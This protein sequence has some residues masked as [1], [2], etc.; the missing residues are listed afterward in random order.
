MSSQNVFKQTLQTVSHVLLYLHNNIYEM[1]GPV[2]L[3]L[4]DEK[5]DMKVPDSGGKKDTQTNY[6]LAD[7]LAYNCVSWG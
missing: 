7:L 6:Y 3:P 4:V 1:A 5:P 2:A